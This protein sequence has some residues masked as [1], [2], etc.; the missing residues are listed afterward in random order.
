LGHFTVRLLQ[1]ATAL[2]AAGLLATYATSPSALGQ[3]QRSKTL[4]LATPNSP[5]TWYLGA[6]GPAG[7]VYDLGKRFADELGVRLK[8]LEVPNGRAA[9]AAVAAGRADI[10]APG[11]AVPH[12]SLPAL[13]FTPPWQRV[14][15]L[16]VYRTGEAVPGD[17]TDLADSAF[18]L[19]VAPDFGPLM[20]RLAATQP[21]LHWRAAPGKGG[22][23]LLIGVAQGKVAYTVVNANEFDLNR[24][25]YPD[26][27]SAFPIGTPQPLAWAVR[28]DDS[29]LYRAAVAFFA[30]AKADRTVAAVLEHYYR[31]HESYDPIVTRRFLAEVG[32]RLPHYAASF[33][34]AA[35][36]TGFSWQ[37]LAAVGYQESH[38]DPKAVSPTGVRGLMMLTV[39]TAKALGIHDRN[40]PHLSIV[41]AARYLAELRARLPRAIKRPNR[42]WMALAA[43]NV[44]YAH[45][46]DARRLT[47][48]EG[49]N[50]NLW[51]DVKKWLPKLNEHR[52]YSHAHYGYANGA[53]AA[54][55][56]ANIQSYEKIL[57]WRL[58]QNT[59]PAQVTQPIENAVVA[60]SE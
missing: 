29:K 45:L 18:Q 24:P 44:G 17:V 57:D 53:G 28:R 1:G 8:V 60:L 47:A 10:A 14:S 35:S 25:F 3:I 31:N 22:D 42:K 32:A 38:W 56:V 41:G 40:D 46:M 49:G 19:T 34:Q 33:E 37:L 5:T 54:Q 27:H 52:Y 58:A 23:E 4:V 30:R 13:R 51:T 55:Y 26:L 15:R 12:A 59:L 7:P 21:D 11:V 39:P 9:L 36:A 43:Y 50:P 16:L 2:A 48:R 6:H 20:R